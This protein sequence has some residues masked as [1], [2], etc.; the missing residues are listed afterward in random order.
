MEVSEKSIREGDHKCDDS[1][2]LR[3][4]EELEDR[5]D[6]LNEW[7]STLEGKLINRGLLPET[8]S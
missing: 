6:F 7:I 2:L 3:R 5:V 1:A 4:I 8:R